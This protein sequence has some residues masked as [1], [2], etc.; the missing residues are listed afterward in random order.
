VPDNRLLDNLSELSRRL[1]KRLPRPHDRTAFVLSGGG[2]RGALQVGMLRALLEQ[3]IVP[4]VIV[5]CSVGALNGAAVA[6]E[7]T[8]ARVGA[9]QDLWLGLDS[10][11]IFPSSLLPT[12]VQLALRGEALHGSEGLR[13]VAE[14]V[15]TARS[16]EELT[17]PFHCV[18]TD[19]AAADECWFDAGPLLDPILAS[20]A[21]PA[22][23]PAV[24]IDGV[25]YMDGAVVND[26]PVTRAVEL[27]AT[28]I[29]V[30]HVGSFDR[31][32]P[33]PKRPLDVALM[34]YWIARRYRF[35]R[36]LARIPE[37][38]EVTVLPT[39]ET[40]DVRY[41]DLTHSGELMDIA[42][43]ASADFLTG[44]SDPT[45]PVTSQPAPAGHLPAPP[46]ALSAE[47]DTDGDPDAPRTAVEA[48]H[49]VAPTSES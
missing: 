18:A 11:E 15:L 37:G 13:A 21:L 41:S 26:V 48:G 14:R 4:D 27:G 38:I 6:E 47:A 42:Y 25:R 2:I 20:A 12:T 19:I 36:D 7:P 34:A 39:G 35:R 24:E 46:P 49:T 8:L 22:V 9:L 33:E 10:S 17:V 31:P 23:F 16:F 45:L 3:R 43:R 30:L 32:R 29:Y 1:L 5:G 44:R 28:R 40:P